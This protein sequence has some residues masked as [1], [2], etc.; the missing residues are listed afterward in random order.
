MDVGWLLSLDSK[1]RVLKASAAL[2]WRKSFGTRDSLRFGDV[3]Q[4]IGFQVF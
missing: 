1:P 4:A 3:I 2:S